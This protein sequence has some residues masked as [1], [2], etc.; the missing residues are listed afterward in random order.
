MTTGARKPP[1]YRTEVKA[2]KSFYWL[3]KI[4]TCSLS[5]VIL[6][7]YLMMAILG[8]SSSAANKDLISEIWTN[9]DTVI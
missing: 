6:T 5:H 8:T 9:G 3:K 7:L 2:S 1:Y 4:L